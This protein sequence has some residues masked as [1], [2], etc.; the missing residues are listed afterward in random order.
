MLHPG[1]PALLHLFQLSA[2]RS[3]CAFPLGGRVYDLGV[4]RRL[5]L[6]SYFNDTLNRTVSS[7]G[8]ER[9]GLRPAFE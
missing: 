4:H 5:P 6:A 3:K 1:R 7:F 9:E 8:L 2:T